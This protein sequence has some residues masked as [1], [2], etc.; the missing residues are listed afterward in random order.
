M[1]AA[2]PTDTPGASATRLAERVKGHDWERVSR[3]LDAQGSARLDG[4]LAPDECQ[5]VVGL[6]AQEALFRSRVEMRRHG[7]GPCTVS[8]CSPSS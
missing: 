4:L 2:V 6:Y 8:M 1:S 7:F 5:R 3:E